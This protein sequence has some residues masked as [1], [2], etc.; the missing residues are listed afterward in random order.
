MKTIEAFIL[1][2]EP[3]Q[4]MKTVEEL[5]QSEAVTKIWL[6]TPAGITAKIKGCKNIAIDTLQSSDTVRKIAQKS[7]G[8]YTLIYLKSTMLKPGYFALERM[9]RIAEDSA[10]G[11]VYADYHAVV[12][13][14][15]KSHPVIDYQEGSL[16]DDFNF[17]SLLCYNTLALKKAVKR[18]K[19]ETY[20]FAGLYDL[21][22]KVSQKHP[23]VHINEYLYTEI[24]ND[25][26]VSFSISV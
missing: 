6:L 20:Q 25:T 5:K 16:R 7:K 14:E 18:I 1:Y 3:E 4:A 21:R 12:G 13:G 17:G 2:S 19:N 9:I 10:A 11:M 24:E 22:L 15:K 26:R 8:D 23:L